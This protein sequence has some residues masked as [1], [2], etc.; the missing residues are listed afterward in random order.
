MNRY[1]SIPSQGRRTHR[2]KL[3]VGWVAAWVLL[4]R[5]ALGG[6]PIPDH[7]IYGTIAIDHRAV[8]N[9]PVQG[10][11]S[12]EA[13]RSKDGV[14]L[15]SYRMGS[16]TKQGP[17]L[18]VLRLPM[19]QG[20]VTADGNAGAAESIVV[21]VKRLNVVR[22]ESSTLQPVSGEARRLDFGVPIDTN[23]N[24]V[25]DPWED[26]N[27]GVPTVDLGRDSDGDGASDVQEYTAG[28]K[29]ND[30]GDIL[31]LQIRS[32]SNESVEVS[33]RAL[34]AQGTGFEGRKTYYALEMSTDLSSW[35]SVGNH[36]RI[37]G[38]NQQVVYQAPPVADGKPAF[39][40]ARVWLEP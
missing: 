19:E 7:V 27:L 31:G 4:G 17:F 2:R 21:T 23:G 1:S 39:F 8:T 38:A 24:G 30:G 13:R 10:N 26:V 3:A 18:Y 12:V 20:N 16:Q 25:P 15:A 9:S 29:P 37:E 36:S 6:V 33:F 32:A 28:T 5:A 35:V 14:L 11:V 40:R 22:H 34:A